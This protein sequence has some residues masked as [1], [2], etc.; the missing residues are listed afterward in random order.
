M[1]NILKSLCEHFGM[2][3]VPFIQRSKIPFESDIFRRNMTLLSPAFFSRQMVVV[4]AMPGAGKTSL[5]FYTINELGSIIL[6]NMPCRAFKPQ[7]EGTL[8]SFGS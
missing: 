7:Q 6:Q 4:S 3:N 8:Q 2:G 5:L 1:N